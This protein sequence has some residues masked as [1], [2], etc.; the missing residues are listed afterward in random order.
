MKTIKLMTLCLIIISIQPPIR[1]DENMPFYSPQNTQTFTQKTSIVSARDYNVTGD[2]VTDDASAIQNAVDAA[3]GSVVLL[4]EG[5]YRIGSNV[6]VPDDVTL[7]L[8]GK[9]SIDAGITVTIGKLRADLYHIFSG[10]GSVALAQGSVE[11]VLPQW[12]GAVGD[13]SNDDTS[14][15]QAAIDTDIFV[16]FPPG[17]YK[18]T[19]ELTSHVTG[20]RIYGAGLNTSNIKVYGGINGIKITHQLFGMSDLR[21]YADTSANGTGSGITIDG[22]KYVLIDRVWIGAADI[23][24]Y[25]D[26]GIIVEDESYYSA[27]RK[28][29]LRRNTYGIHARID[30]GAAGPNELLIDN[31][32]I[33]YGTHGVYNEAAERLQV[34]DCGLE[35]Y[36]VRAIH[37]ESDGLNVTS[38]RFEKDG[39]VPVE[40]TAGVKDCYIAGNH[41]VYS[42]PNKP[43]L[44]NSGNEHNHI[45]GYQ[46]LFQMR[47]I[48]GVEANVYGGSIV[49]GQSGSLVTDLKMEA[50]LG[51]L[52]LNA[53]TS[54]KVVDLQTDTEVTAS[55]RLEM[56]T[57]FL[58][59]PT[60]G[61]GER[62]ENR[63]I[64]SEEF[65]NAV[66]TANNVTVTADQAAAPNGRTTADQIVSTSN[67]GYCYQSVSVS[68]GDLVW[69]S[70]WVRAVS[71]TA[72]N[73]RLRLLG[74]SGATLAEYTDISV[75]TAWERIEVT[76]TV[77]GNGTMQVRLYPD[78]ST[79]DSIYAWGI[80]C[81][82]GADNSP[83]P[84][85]KTLE[86]AIAVDKPALV[87]ANSIIGRRIAGTVVALT[88]G[89]TIAADMDDGNVFTIATTGNCTINASNGAAGQRATFIITDDA[90]GGRVVTFGTNFK[91]SGTLTGTASKIATV[92][93]VYD[94]TNWCEVSRTTGL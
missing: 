48:S 30:N 50:F 74:T 33:V 76:G 61:F 69:A 81:V 18:I 32:T 51:D 37:N 12:W 58:F 35:Q 15:I 7:W 24:G 21:I 5:T 38:T 75:G 62:A 16:C 92:D 14:A 34:K 26:K 28:C 84:Y 66:W 25:F 68:D 17:T 36:T 71:G 70:V 22:A 80:Q 23:N 55:K 31:T 85:I 11:Y 10:D 59:T 89:A 20:Q 56:L 90:T 19:A 87:A 72:G 8:I 79:Q 42:G 64:Y 39:V 52:Q 29:Y 6:T 88:Y 86:T 77:S 4:P 1:G 67:Y 44:D 73:V 3:H 45:E 60:G 13:D 40:L 65:D 82:I 83:V 94:G 2:G 78:N 49:L 53:A 54:G 57:P 9:L 46:T 43:V 91:S 47:S 41:F 93:F 63:L 27:I